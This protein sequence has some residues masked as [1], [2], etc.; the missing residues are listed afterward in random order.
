MTTSRLPFSE[1]G[2]DRRLAEI[3]IVPLIPAISCRERENAEAR[4][5]RYWI[6]RSRHRFGPKDPF[7]VDMLARREG[8]FASGARRLSSKVWGEKNVN[9]L[10]KERP[11]SLPKKIHW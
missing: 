6:S 8:F 1:S 10:K 4:T 9:M 11:E 5:V 3:K 2:D 7:F